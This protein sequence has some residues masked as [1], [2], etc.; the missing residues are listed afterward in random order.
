MHA[1]FILLAR[2]FPALLALAYDP[3]CRRLRCLSYCCKRCSLRFSLSLES[4][5]AKVVVGGTLFWDSK[6]WISD[7]KALSLDV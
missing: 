5:F 6:L 1:A 2:Y 7:N 4:V 3:S